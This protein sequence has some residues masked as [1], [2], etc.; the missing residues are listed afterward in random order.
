MKY[1]TVVLMLTGSSL[2]L[3]SP[4]ADADHTFLFS[5]PL[6]VLVV[7][8]HKIAVQ[9]EVTLQEERVLFRKKTGGP[10]FSLPLKEIDIAQTARENGVRL[11]AQRLVV[12]PQ[13]HSDA[14]STVATMQA[15]TTVGL[16]AREGERRK[17][18][19]VSVA[20]LEDRWTMF[21]GVSGIGETNINN[22]LEGTADVGVIPM[23][24]FNY[25]NKGQRATLETSYTAAFHSYSR[26]EKWNRT[27]HN[28]SASFEPR[29]RGRWRS[30][31]EADVSLK[32]A[33]EDRDLSDRYTLSQRFRFRLTE[34]DQ[35]RLTAGYRL[36]LYEDDPS[37]DARNRFGGLDFRHRFAS[38]AQ[39]SLGYR[40]DLN[41]SEG[42]RRDYRRTTLSTGLSIPFAGDAFA[43]I[44]VR[45]REQEYPNRL[46]R[47]GGELVSRQDERWLG[48][49]SVGRS[50]FKTTA[51]ALE[52]QYEI[53]FSNDPDKEYNG[54]SVGLSLI[55]FW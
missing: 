34:R 44:G 52:Y 26:S 2:A 27:S 15:V 33:N 7:S 40:Q 39:W 48:S 9:G 55:R 21:T 25:R 51:M 22:E 13:P 1:L 49:L 54:H 24:G 36:K 32:G 5:S 30:E 14:I 17:S 43:R 20:T 29:W 47:L 45:R 50:F 16:A 28:L 18:R 10:L 23:I 53:R 31:T 19:D 4:Q 46:V 12:D 37:S 6:R 3:A 38:G 8:G 11:A 42:E 35:L 41:Q